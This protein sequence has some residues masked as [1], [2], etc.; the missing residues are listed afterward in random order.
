MDNK[1]VNEADI[2]ANLAPNAKNVVKLQRD[3]AIKAALK[4][5][6]HSTGILTPARKAAKEKAKLAKQLR[7]DYS[8][9]VKILLIQKL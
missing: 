4:S 1:K 5:A 6:K 9:P 2:L 8:K 3:A 7:L